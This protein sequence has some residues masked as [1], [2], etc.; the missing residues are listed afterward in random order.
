MSSIKSKVGFQYM[1]EVKTPTPEEVMCLSSN[2]EDKYN[3]VLFVLDQLYKG[4]FDE[5]EAASMASLCLLAQAA[6]LSD[7]ASADLKARALKRDVTFA[8]TNAYSKLKNH[9]GPDGKRLSETALS[10]LVNADEEVQQIIKEQINA[11]KD[12]KHLTNIH[13]LL[14]EAHITFRSI[15]AKNN[16]P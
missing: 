13:S 2:F 4:S 5:A 9:P 14:K 15:K 1:A 6:L 16:N 3:K 8:E 7:L 11:E 10:Q 12:S